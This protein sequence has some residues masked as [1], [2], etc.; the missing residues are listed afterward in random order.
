MKHGIPSNS[1]AVQGYRY[2]ARVLARHLAELQGQTLDRPAI[3]ADA[4]IPTLLRAARYGPEPWH[5]RSY[6]A[7]AISFHPDRGIRDEGVPPP[8]YFLDTAR[9]AGAAATTREPN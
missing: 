5:P 2:N 8:M 7:R 1:G 6:L 9:F 4:G 3:A